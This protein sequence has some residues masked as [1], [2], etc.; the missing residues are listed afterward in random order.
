MRLLLSATYSGHLGYL[1][2]RLKMLVA[3]VFG[4]ELTKDA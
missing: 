1:G 4:R 3:I 2:A